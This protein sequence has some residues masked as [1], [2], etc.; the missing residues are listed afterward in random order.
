[1]RY[2]DTKLNNTGKK[3]KYTQNTMSRSYESGSGFAS[4]FYARTR[5]ER[6]TKLEKENM[7]LKRQIE[8]DNRIIR[9]Q[10]SQIYKMKREMEYYESIH[11]KWIQ[12]KILSEKSY[13]LE[14]T[15]KTLDELEKDAVDEYLEV[16]DCRYDEEQ[17]YDG[18][19]LWDGD[20]GVFEDC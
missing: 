11:L 5:P 3:I 13:D 2:S 17:L 20:C 15:I 18:K 8:N 10:Q 9:S 6:Q 16:H 7:E 12:N 19:T 4:E 1:M 14:K